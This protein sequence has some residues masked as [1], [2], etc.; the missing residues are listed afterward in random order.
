MGQAKR[1]LEEA[2]AKGYTVPR[3]RRFVCGRCVRNNILRQILEA[4]SVARECGYCGSNTAA[5]IETLLD[6]ISEAAFWGYTDPANELPYES[7]EGGYQGEVFHAYELIEELGDWTD[8][9]TLR[10]DVEMAFAGSIWC[11]ENYF[12]VDAAQRL[13]FGW[14]GFVNQIKH[15]TRFLFLQE[16]GDHKSWETIPPNQMLDEVGG[17]LMGLVKPMPAGS[18]FYRARVTKAGEKP[19]SPTDLGPPPEALSMDSRMSPAGIPMF[20]AAQDEDT[21]V[22]ETF[23]P[24]LAHDRGIT[25]G[26]WR[27]LRDIAVLDLTDLPEFPDVFDSMNRTQAPRIAFIHEFVRSLTSPVKRGATSIDYVPTQVVTEYVRHRMKAHGRPVDAILY[28]SSKRD[29]GVAVVVFA[30]QDNCRPRTAATVWSTEEQFLKLISVEHYSPED[31]EQLWAG[32]SP[33]FG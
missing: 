3:A 18:I 2:M 17:L 24:T 14:T 22:L 27:V 4:S 9:P 11:K 23:D 32:P 10:E 30:V 33:T 31:F 12:G 21:A 6:E 29:D 20:Y 13:R 16:R 7:R 19:V 1:L 26:R 15:K 5:P 28:R 25:I 8:S